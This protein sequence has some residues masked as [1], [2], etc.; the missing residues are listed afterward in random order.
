MSAAFFLSKKNV[1]VTLVESN[2]IGRESSGASAGTM[3]LQNKEFGS[4]RLSEKGLQT[5]KELQTELKDIGFRQTGGLRVAENSEQFKKLRREVDKQRKKMGLKIELMSRSEVKAFAPYL[6]DSIEGASFCEKDAYGDPLLATLSI[7]KAAQALGTKIRVNEP[8]VG[9]KICNS[10]KFLVQTTK[11][12]YE[13][14]RVV[15]CAG[16]WS[17]NI[18]Q[19]V[20]LN[21]PIRLSSMQCIITEQVP[22]LFSHV[23]IHIEGNLT[24]KQ[25][26]RGN[27]QIGGGWKA[28]GD[29]QTRTKRILFES[30]Q[31]NSRR[32]C[33]VIPALKGI[34]MIRC[35]AGLEGRSPDLLPLLGN[36]K[37]IPGFYSATC[38]RSGFSLGPIMGK[39]VTELIL[40]KKMSFPIAEFDINRVVND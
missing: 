19:M 15:N 32:A 30:L 29:V 33:R 27:I 40:K 3:S 10:D 22:S 34:N 25:R 13:C 24:M 38:A 9:I 21:I 12:E 26:D 4:I 35:W 23:I 5:W 16:V 1:E 36:F 7:V 11:C 6:G 20:G 14:K 31:G 8:V 18:F 37:K 39:L 2:E 28:L 17:K